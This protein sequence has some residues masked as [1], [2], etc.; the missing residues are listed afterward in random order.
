[1]LDYNSKDG[2][3]DWAKEN[4]SKHIEKDTVKFFRTKEPKYWVASH[5]KNIAHKMASG[6]ILVN[7]DSDILMPEGFCE[8]ILEA[9]NKKNIIMAFDSMDPYGY[10]GCAGI[11]GSLKEH[12][13]SVNGYDE[14]IC[15]GWGYDDMNFQFRVRMHNNLE[16]FIPPKVCLCIPHSDD[17]RIENCQLKNILV[18]KD[19]SFALCQEAAFSKDYVANK[20]ISWGRARLTKNF[21]EEIKI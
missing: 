2:L 1:L 9:F 3:E 13:Y 19:L 6:D 7:I 18:T 5:A 4:L 11:I 21:K 10:N 16:L 15:M 8:F 17:V 12:F 20:S 14:N